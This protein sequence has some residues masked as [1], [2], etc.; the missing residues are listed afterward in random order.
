[1][2]VVTEHPAPEGERRASPRARRLW[3]RV[4]DN[5]RFLQRRMEQEGERLRVNEVLGHRVSRPVLSPDG[6]IAAAGD[7]VSPSVVDR[8]RS[9]GVLPALLEAAEPG[10]RKS[11]KDN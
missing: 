4:R 6:P 5:V 1:V 7:R 2:A 10:P 11:D 9:S 8:A 3:E